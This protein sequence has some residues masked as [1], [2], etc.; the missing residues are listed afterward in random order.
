MLRVLVALAPV[1]LLAGYIS[2]L[3]ACAAEDQPCDRYVDYICVCHADDPG[4]D[5]AEI[6]RTF[7]GADPDVQN[8]CALEL[9]EQREVDEDAGLE[10][11]V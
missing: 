5:C 7:Q 3:G 8:A 2:L 9:A 1:S 6:E 4:F 11:D 10:C